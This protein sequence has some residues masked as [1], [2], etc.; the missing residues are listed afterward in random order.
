MRL[1]WHVVRKDA[2]RLCLALVLWA[3]LITVQHA[4]EWWLQHLPADDK[5]RIQ[6]MRWFTTMLFVLPVGIG[7][8]LAA[9]IMMEDPAAGSTAFWKSR[10]ISGARML[11]A[12]V[13]GCAV[14]LI[15]LPALVG[16]PWQLGGLERDTTPVVSFVGSIRWHALA[17][18][19]GIV[20]ASFSATAGKFLAWTVGLQVVSLSA[21]AILLEKNSPALS[22]IKAAAAMAPVR[23]SAAVLVVAVALAV[24]VLARYQRRPPRAINS[25]LA[26]G[27]T[28]AVLLLLQVLA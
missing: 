21:A 25:I 15:G 20:V 7:Y 3:V 5:I 9:G 10:P 28:G 6:W 24:S 22:A 2:R 14:L 26:A 12:K 13:L 16:L 18:A 8:V 11:G 1:A 27:A 17:V 4:A 23:I 19:A